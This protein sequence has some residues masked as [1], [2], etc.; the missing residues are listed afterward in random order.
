MPKEKRVKLVKKRKPRMSQ[1]Q[2]QNVVVNIHKPTRKP[3]GCL[4]KP[5]REQHSSFV[6][7]PSFHSR[8]ETVMYRPEAPRANNLEKAQIQQA[9]VDNRAMEVAAVKNAAQVKTPIHIGAQKTKSILT[10]VG[11]SFDMKELSSLRTELF[12]PTMP[13]TIGHPLTDK[14]VELAKRPHNTLIT[15][16]SEA[17]EGHTEQSSFPF[18]G[19]SR[20]EGNL[21]SGFETYAESPDR[22]S[23]GEGIGAAELPDRMTEYIAKHGT[24][25]DLLHKARLEGAKIDF[26][27]YEQ[28][29]ES[30]AGTILATT[31]QNSD[32]AILDSPELKTEQTLIR[33]RGRPR[34][35][36]RDEAKARQIERSQVQSSMTKEMRRMRNILSPE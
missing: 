21:E 6:I 26:D 30:G 18:F 9:V 22:R 24:T 31:Q 36:S 23:D 34:M 35:Y 19:K 17:N 5:K 11:D 13:S 27:P 16:L 1:K 29:E 33:G 10:Q 15:V 8:P 25:G 32:T 4:E 3:C 28:A 7:A 12:R 14:Q 20:S 2:K